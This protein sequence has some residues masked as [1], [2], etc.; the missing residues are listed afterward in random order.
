MARKL[1]RLATTSIFILSLSACLDGKVKTSA[2]QE[3]NPPPGAPQTPPSTDPSANN[4]QP[5]AKALAPTQL[6]PA[7]DTTLNANVENV[8]L[9]WV[10]PDSNSAFL[11]RVK[12]LDDATSRDSRNNCDY[13]VYL[14]LDNY[15]A[16]KENGKHSVQLKVKSGHRYHFWIHS[17][18]GDFKLSDAGTYSVASSIKFKVNGSAPNNN[19]GSSSSSTSSSSSSSSNPPTTPP[20]INKETRTPA[21]AKRDVHNNLVIDSKSAQGILSF[22]YENSF[23]NLKTGFPVGHGIKPHIEN[24]LFYNL[25]LDGYG[26][27]PMGSCLTRGYLMSDS[28]PTKKI[29][30]ANENKDLLRDWSQLYTRDPNEITPYKNTLIKN[31]DVQRAFRTYN[32]VDGKLMKS[33]N[34]LPHT[35]TF[36]SYYGGKT[37]GEKNA[38]WLAIQ[39]SIIKNSDN[40]GMIVG[41]THYRGFLYHN[42]EIG[43]DAAFVADGLKRI[44]NDYI[45]HGA[46]PAY[47]WVCTNNIGASSYNY[48]PV[49]LIDIHYTNPGVG[50][51]S[52]GAP[53]VIIGQNKDKLQISFAHNS[54]PGEVCRYNTI[55]DALN[56]N[57]VSDGCG[58]FERP[59]FLE[60]SCA[61][62]KNPPANCE[63]R[64]GYIP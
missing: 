6:S 39:D 33:G 48:A 46:T 16:T 60:L 3:Q 20:V 15:G 1:P 62:W 19:S 44:R 51:R 57:D 8:T 54:T 26:G 47:E 53:V 9:S 36:Q 27:L 43:C 61:G 40:G 38:Q 22:E 4:P 7:D 29:C 13:G 30:L 59:P 42:L 35:D 58:K 11:I 18:R 31:V 28:D 41:D 64:R 2:A 12:D 56:D 50:V 32:H 49:W 17:A 45:Y 63:S 25:K 55:E 52:N 14:C 5:L 37:A 24:R 21:W 23:A 34:D 10:Q